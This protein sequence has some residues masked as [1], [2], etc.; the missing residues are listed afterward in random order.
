MADCVCV[1]G[2]K[3]NEFRVRIAWDCRRARVVGC[4]V[5]DCNEEENVG[6]QNWL[7]LCDRQ[8]T[9]RGPLRE[10][11]KNGSGIAERGADAR[12]KRS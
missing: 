6:L 12:R 3:K 2:C 11:E 5:E 10:L 8:N 1:L 7:W 9:I 4:E